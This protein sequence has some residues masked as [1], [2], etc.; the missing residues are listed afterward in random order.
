MALPPTEA[1]LVQ[2][3]ENPKQQN[4]NNSEELARNQKLWNTQEVLNYRYTLTKNCFCTSDARGPVIVEVGNGTTTSVTSVNADGSVNRQLFDKYDTIPKLFD[5]IE[6][7]ITRNADSL[8]VEYD[9]TFGYPTQ[10]N[11]DYSS[12]MADE[13]L[14]LTIENFTKSANSSRAN[15]FKLS[16]AFVEVT[17]S[18]TSILGGPQLNYRDNNINR[19]F[20]GEAIRV[21]ETELGQLI[22]VTLEAVPDLRTVTFTL[23]L[24]LVKL[25]T[26]SETI[27]IRVPS[28]TTTTRTTI[29]GPGAGAEKTYKAIDLRGTAQ[30]V[31]S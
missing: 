11:I 9:P 22:T 17:Y 21:R 15:I 1:Q 16:G 3:V 27:R 6:D 2:T 30:F 12:Q 13:E 18:D 8:K 14:F 25:N 31:V 19:T 24:P 26:V 4:A 23:I 10:I 5:A 20:M 29:A 7:A 28:I